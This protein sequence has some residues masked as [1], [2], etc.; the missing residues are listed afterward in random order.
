MR[1]QNVLMVACCF[2]LASFWSRASVRASLV[3]GAVRV[4]WIRSLVQCCSSCFSC[5][6]MHNRKQRAARANKLTPTNRKIMGQIGNS[7]VSRRTAKL[8][9]VDQMASLVESKDKKSVLFNADVQMLYG[10]VFI[11]N[12]CLDHLSQAMALHPHYLDVFLRTQN[13]LLRGDGPLPYSYRH[14]IAILAAA[15]HRCSYL[16][17]LQKQEFL[18]IGGDPNWLK[19]LQHIPKKLRDIYEIN[20]ILS[21]RPWLITKEHIEKLTKGVDNWTLSEVAHAVVILAHFHTMSSLVY[22]C[23]IRNEIDQENGHTFANNGQEQQR[24]TGAASNTKTKSATSPSESDTE[25]G[26]E[27]LM[28]RMKELQERPPEEPSPEEKAKRFEKVENQA[29]GLAA[30]SPPTLSAD[31]SKFIEDPTFSYQDFARR[32]EMSDISTFRIQDYSWDDHGYSLINSIYSDVGTYLD[33]M[34][35]V[36]YGLTYFTMGVKKG[37]DTSM[38]R[39]AVWNYIQCIFGIRHDDYDYSE[40]NHMIERNLKAYV[41]TVCV[42]PERITRKDYDSVMRDFQHSEKMDELGISPPLYVSP[43]AP[44]GHLQPPVHVNL[45]VVEAR[46]QAELLYALRA[47]MQYMT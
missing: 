8:S 21:H 23:G 46:K 5:R 28:Q 38:F 22:G 39:R 14:Y 40:V 12:S 16:V 31:I 3:V 11:Q 20:K 34:F 42:Y 32:G 45:M 2:L 18:L 26:V 47:I 9:D 33:E 24:K 15:R 43:N 29:L 30:G 7:D 27:T 17:N 36:T 10:E 37:I 25:V 4:S 35:K 13:F 19:G 6:F 1:A 41:K 44:N